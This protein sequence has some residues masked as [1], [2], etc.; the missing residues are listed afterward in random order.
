MSSDEYSIIF[1]RKW[2]PFR[3]CEECKKRK[4]TTKLYDVDSVSLMSHIEYN[5]C[6]KCIKKAMQRVREDEWVNREI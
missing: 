3:R 5:V 6:N 4:L 2:L 1:K